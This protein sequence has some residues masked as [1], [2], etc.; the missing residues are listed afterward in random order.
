MAT[1]AVKRFLSESGP[2]GIVILE[3]LD[4]GL[5]SGEIRMSRIQASAWD[6]ERDLCH[7]DG[8][9]QQSGWRWEIGNMKTVL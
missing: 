3:A 2:V 7:V 5:G 6:F 8:M 9:E 4:A 1:P